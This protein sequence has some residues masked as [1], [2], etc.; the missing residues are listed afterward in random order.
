MARTGTAILIG[1]VLDL[2]APHP[3][4]GETFTLQPSLWRDE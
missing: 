1:Q 3:E 2:P 4:H